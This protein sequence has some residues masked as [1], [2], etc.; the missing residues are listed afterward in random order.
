M[1]WRTQYDRVTTEYYS[2]SGSSVRPVYSSKV[3]DSGI[4]ELQMVGEEDTYPLIQSYKD[5]CSI[6]YLLAKYA[7]GDVNAL[8]KVQGVYG[9]FTQLPKSFAEVL[10]RVIDGENYFN[11]LPLDVRQQF[12]NDFRRWFAEA[13]TDS[14]LASMGIVSADP[15]SDDVSD[16]SPTDPVS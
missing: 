13:G 3:N 10:Q 8:S 6:N 11:S 15:V 9:D 14:W 1:K 4:L 7:N 12:A 2:C 16:D 5:S